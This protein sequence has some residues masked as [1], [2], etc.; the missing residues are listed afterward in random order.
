MTPSDPT[1]EPRSARDRAASLVA[2]AHSF[3]DLCDAGLMDASGAAW[4]IDPE[5]WE[6][7]D[8]A[9]RTLEWLYTALLLVST[10]HAQSFWPLPVE[11]REAAL[12]ALDG[13]GWQDVS[14]RLRAAFA[15][16]PDSPEDAEFS[17][18]TTDLMPTI[19]ARFYRWVVDHAGDLSFFREPPEP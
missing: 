8:G 13:A 6:T 10:D 1:S 18:P 14:A 9:D 5:R 2:S 11:M 7:L 16:N 17:F 15:A 19:E 4:E 12:S 3:Y